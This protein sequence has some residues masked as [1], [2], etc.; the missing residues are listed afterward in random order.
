M[1]QHSLIF[2]IVLDFRSGR[3]TLFMKIS[4]NYP[5]GIVWR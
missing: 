5:N 1:K 3:F 4:L 2:K